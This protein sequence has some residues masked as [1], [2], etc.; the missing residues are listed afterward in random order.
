MLSAWESATGA[1][2]QIGY[3]TRGLSTSYQTG[4]STSYLD[5]DESGALIMVKRGSYKDHY[6]FSGSALLSERNGQTA[7]QTDYIYLNGQLVG[8]YDG[9]LSNVI[10]GHLGQPQAMYSETG[11][12]VWRGVIDGFDIKVSTQTR[13]LKARFPG[14]YDIL[15]NGLYYNYF[16]DY[17]PKLGRYV[18]SDP[19]GLAGGLNTYG[20]VGVNP[21][22]NI[23]PEGLKY[24]NALACFAAVETVAGLAT[25]HTL[26]QRRTEA[27]ENLS[28]MLKVVDE[29]IADCD[30]STD[31]GK[32]KR[33]Q[34]NDIRKKII[35][36]K[37]ELSVYGKAAG[38]FIFG[39]IG[40][41]LAGVACGA[42]APTPF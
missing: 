27:E 34:L 2:S 14:Q 35:I 9:Q 39:S 31:D 30:T 3:D 42:L 24:G 1:T 18:Q 20:Y 5:R 6:T 36:M 16:R 25:L 23:D 21:I 41:G 32:I 33:I 40:A 17:D 10:N 28:H 8:I 12:L 13:P 26:G 15:G 38:T 37:T 29:Q 22:R 19:I 7:K 4:G 11:A